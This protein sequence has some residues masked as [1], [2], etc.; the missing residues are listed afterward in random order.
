MR[1]VLSR[2][3]QLSRHRQSIDCRDGMDK[4]LELHVL[5]A[6]QGGLHPLWSQMLAHRIVGGQKHFGFVLFGVIMFYKS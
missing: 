2:H 1:K 4:A 5:G 3:E 6:S